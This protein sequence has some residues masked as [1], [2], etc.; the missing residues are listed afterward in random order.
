MKKVFLIFTTC[1]FNNS[2]MFEDVY[3]QTS[4]FISMVDIRV[5]TYGRQKGQH[6][7]VHQHLVIGLRLPRIVL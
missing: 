1:A 5:L 4:T 2:Y 6:S 3:V 7:R